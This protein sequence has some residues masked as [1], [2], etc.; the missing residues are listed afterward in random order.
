MESLKSTIF[1]DRNVAYGIAIGKFLWSE[2]PSLIHKMKRF[3]NGR[4]NN[5]KVQ[6]TDIYASYFTVCAIYISEMIQWI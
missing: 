4:C 3:N 6:I 5:L 2:N 1:P